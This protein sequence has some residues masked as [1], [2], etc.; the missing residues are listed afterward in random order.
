[1]SD[2]KKTL[3]IPILLITLGVGW[4]LTTLD[5]VPNVNW[6]WT[7]GLALVGILAFVIA[8]IDKIS[9]AVGPFFIV[10]VYRSCGRQGG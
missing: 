3:F 2:D 1:M 10:A 8:G 6:I 7:L 4:L 9:V 5:V